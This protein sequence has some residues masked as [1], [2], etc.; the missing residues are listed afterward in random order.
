MSNSPS[1][2]LK[3]VIYRLRKSPDEYMGRVT[4]PDEKTALVR[5]AKE[6]KITDP[7]RK[8]RLI[9]VRNEQERP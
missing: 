1:E 2:E 7:E 9:A 5:A 8:R 3:W 4:A 6:F